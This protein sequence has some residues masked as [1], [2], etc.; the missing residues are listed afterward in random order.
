MPWLPVVAAI[1]GLAGT[2]ISVGETL[3]NS[4][5]GGAAPKPAAPP[6]PKPPDPAALLQQKALVAQQNPNEVAATAGL[7]NPAFLALMDQLRAGTLGQP[8][9][10]AA[11]ASATGQQ[12]SPAN[13]QPTNAAVS[14]QPINL[15][16]FINTST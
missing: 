14:G 5:G 15:S 2:G 12:F 1:A 16:D 10:A 3:A 11:G 13:S 4:G 7:A 6:P 9:S 8:G